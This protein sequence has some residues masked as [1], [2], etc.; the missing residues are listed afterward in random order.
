MTEKRFKELC[1]NLL[2]CMVISNFEYDVDTLLKSGAI[3]LDSLSNN[4]KDIY[5]VVAAI[6]ERY[7]RHCINGSAYEKERARARKT[8]KQYMA[9]I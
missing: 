9:Y 1:N 5:P 2:K 3:D 8:M 4:Y 7:V 6:L